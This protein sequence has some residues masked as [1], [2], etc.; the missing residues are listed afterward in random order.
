M[1]PIPHCLFG[2]E[3]VCEHIDP[4]VLTLRIQPN[5]GIQLRFA[6]KVPGHDVV[7]G[8]VVMDMSYVETFGG[9]PPEAYERLLLDAMRGDAMLFSRRDAVEAAWTWIDPILRHVEAHPPRDFP[10]YAPGSWGPQ[11]CHDWMRRDHRAWR[12]P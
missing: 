10:N 6:S 2:R 1:T 7:V 12:E 4:N 8:S 11:V 3:D 5:E 9:E